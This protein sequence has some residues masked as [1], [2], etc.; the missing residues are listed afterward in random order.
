MPGARFLVE[1]RGG[2]FM[3]STPLEGTPPV[4]NSYGHRSGQYTSY[5]NTF[6]FAIALV[7]VSVPPSLN[8]S[9]AS[10]LVASELINMSLDNQEREINNI[11]ILYKLF[12]FA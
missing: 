3:P 7:P 8:T 1:G 5:W 2:V 12:T 4:L 6:L 9:S 10:F 11:C